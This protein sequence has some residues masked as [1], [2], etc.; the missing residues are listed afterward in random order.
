[1][2]KIFFLV[3]AILLISVTN[4]KAQT[5]VTFNINLQPLLADSSFIPG[6]HFLEVRGDLRPFTRTTAFQMKDDAEIDSV[7]SVTLNFPRRYNGE[8]L[9][10]NYFIKSIRGGERKEFLPRYLRLNGREIE[11]PP[12]YFDAHPN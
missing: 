12:Y 3:A 8:T 4:L 7:Y 2:K 10:F 5:E 1:M 11:L 6:M 9:T